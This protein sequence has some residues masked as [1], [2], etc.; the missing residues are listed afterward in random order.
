LGIGDTEGMMQDPR[1]TV[2]P[3]IQRYDGTWI[4]DPVANAR[5]SKAHH[6]HHIEW[7][8]IDWLTVASWGVA[9]TVIIAIWLCVFATLCL[10][11]KSSWLGIIIFGLFLLIG[12]AFQA[13]L[14]RL[15]KANGRIY[16]EESQEPPKET[17]GR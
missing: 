4:N 15:I 9:G 11:F 2:R 13:S 17:E 7:S 14:S 16:R 5:P 6:W 12:F 10:L 1:K 3:E 8:R